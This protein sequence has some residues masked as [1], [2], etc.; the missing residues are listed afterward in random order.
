MP[1]LAR[2]RHIGALARLLHRHQLDADAG[3][4]AERLLRVIELH[5][6]ATGHLVPDPAK[7]RNPLGYFNS[8]LSA[9]EPLSVETP[10][11]ARS[12]TPVAK[13]RVDD[14]Q[15]RR[16]VEAEDPARRA[17]VIAQ[18]R[19]EIAQEQLNQPTRSFASHVKQPSAPEPR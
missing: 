11:K 13:W 7:Q 18:I 14:A 4:S 17:A 1:W 3:W 8:L 2:D 5:N 15:R 12:F 10:F 19:A 6:R 9:A 16:E